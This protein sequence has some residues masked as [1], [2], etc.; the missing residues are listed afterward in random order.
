MLG[1]KDSTAKADPNANSLL[2]QGWKE[3]AWFSLVASGDQPPR[4][5]EAG[6]QEE[7]GHRL[8]SGIGS[9]GL[10]KR[11]MENSGVG[12]FRKDFGVF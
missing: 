3:D 11:Q 7:K 6:R 2:P 1:R 5:M 8:A 12:D 4:L 10:E 9:E